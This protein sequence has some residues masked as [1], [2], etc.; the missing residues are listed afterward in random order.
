MNAAAEYNK[1]LPTPS[2]VSRPFWDAAKEHR[3]LFQRC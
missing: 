3:L 1:P 2:A